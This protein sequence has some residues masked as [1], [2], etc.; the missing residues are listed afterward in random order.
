MPGG[1]TGPTAGPAGTPVPVISATVLQQVP[2]AWLVA[3]FHQAHDRFNEACQDP[4]ASQELFAALFEALGWA[5]VL[6]EE[7]RKP[8]M[9]N[10]PELMALRFVRDRVVHD[11]ALAVD[12]RNIPNP[13]A[14]PLRAAG[15]SQII[16]PQV[17]WEWFWKS[18][19]DLP[20][21]RNPF[22]KWPRKQ[23][24]RVQYDTIFASSPVRDSLEALRRIF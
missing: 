8:Q 18:S 17:I 3:G 2:R 9:H 19:Q 12:G 14:P 5:G 21:M 16:A 10:I 15:G 22:A 4:N 13:A 6:E 23:A 11:W 1:P 20:K 7:A 24:E